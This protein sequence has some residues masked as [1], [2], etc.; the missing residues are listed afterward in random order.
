VFKYYLNPCLAACPTLAF[1]ARALADDAFEAPDLNT[2]ARLYGLIVEPGLRCRPVTFKPWMLATPIL[3]TMLIES[4]VDSRNGQAFQWNSNITRQK[5]AQR[6]RKT[7]AKVVSRGFC[8][9]KNAWQVE[10]LL[11]MTVH[12]NAK[13]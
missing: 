3:H 7:S 11:R 5:K 8:R 4:R 12:W 13:T 6:T 10:K 1:L 9:Q 2:P